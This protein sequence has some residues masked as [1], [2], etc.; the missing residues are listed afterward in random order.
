MS[1][2][3]AFGVVHKGTVTYPQNAQPR[4]QAQSYGGQQDDNTGKAVAA[5][6]AGG[7]AIV[8]APV[9]AGGAYGYHKVKPAVKAYKKVKGLVTS[10]AGSAILNAAKTATKL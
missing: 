3:S 9:V 2:V 6:A 5:G 8:G 10:G 7:A 4:P 1:E